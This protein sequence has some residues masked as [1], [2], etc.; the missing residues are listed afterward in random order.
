[1]VHVVS[2]CTILL[3]CLVQEWYMPAE[4]VPSFNRPVHRHLHPVMVQGYMFLQKNIFLRCSLAKG[5]KKENRRF[6]AST[7][8]NLKF[9]VIIN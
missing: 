7:P 3:T 4:H 8:E 9:N 5:I 6:T 2:T 1:M